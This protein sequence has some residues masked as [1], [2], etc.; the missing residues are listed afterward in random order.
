[1][2]AGL[3]LS[4]IFRTLAG[5]TRALVSGKGNIATWLR[6]A[7]WMFGSSLI[8]RIA[9]LIQT[10]MIARSIG[11][12]DYG[13]YALLFSTISLLTPIV[14]LQLPYTVVYFIARFQ[15]SDVDRAAS[16]LALAR[17][18]TMITTV[19]TIALVCLFS[20]RVSAWLFANDNLSSVVI[21]GGLLLLTSTQ[22]GLNDAVLQAS[23]RFRN[24]A[25]IRVGISVLSVILLIP[26]M[27]YWPNLDTILIILV[28]AALA[29]LAAVW[30]PARSVDHELHTDKPMR[31]LVAYAPEVFRFAL[32]SGMF[33]LAQGL[34]TWVGNYYLTQRSLSGFSDLAVINTGLQWRTP[35]LVVMASLASALLPM[36]S[37]LIGEDDH[38][39]T[40]RLQRFSMLFNVGTAFAFAAGVI[41]LSPWILALYG[42]EFK[43]QT[44]LFSLFIATLVPMVYCNVHQQYHVAR[45]QVW[46]QFLLFLPYFVVTIGGTMWFAT[47]L[48]GSTVGYIQLA[49]WLLT[50]ALMTIVAVI[51]R[52]SG[53]EPPSRTQ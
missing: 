45:G 26:A 5:W 48:Q 12:E 10:V 51:E 33:S 1:M 24:L 4:G 19:L 52:I 34:S 40:K 44:F 14:G 37:R 16:I 39:Q 7:G 25:L 42:P 28:L 41:V 11:I 47:D 15:K 6:G 31:K 46:T 20:G 13:R 23:E 8:E 36:L 2:S 35:V 3:S 9:A 17:R 43:G 53:A 30:I 29:R 21:L 18:L 32:P 27:F 50:A 49:A 38:H 22:I